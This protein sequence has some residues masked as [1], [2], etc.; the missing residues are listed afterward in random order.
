MLITGWDTM[1][2]WAFV[3]EMFT[4]I[5]SLPEK[6]LL[7]KFHTFQA[8]RGSSF[9]H[10]RTM[11][12][13]EERSSFVAENRSTLMPVIKRTRPETPREKPNC[14]LAEKPTENMEKL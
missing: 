7:Y 8:D 2:G 12:T 13:D 5:T 14:F 6:E 9:F 11:R 1:G 10:K 4:N 3:R